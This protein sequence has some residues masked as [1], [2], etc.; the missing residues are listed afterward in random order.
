M[1]LV[2]SNRKIV[3]ASRSSPKKVHI[4]LYDTFFKHLHV[5]NH[6]V[7]E[8]QNKVPPMIKSDLI[9]TNIAISVNNSALCVNK[10]ALSV[11]KSV[12]SVNN[13]GLSVKRL[14]SQ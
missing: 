2:T 5:H 3:I 10:N 14:P 4:I 8:G 1:T 9:A 13:S 6:W 11:N 12:L 7:Q